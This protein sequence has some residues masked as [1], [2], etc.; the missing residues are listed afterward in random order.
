MKCQ[1][2][3]SKLFC[4]FTC[5]IIL[6]LARDNLAKNAQKTP[7]PQR[8]RAQR[9]RLLSF[10]AP[11]PAISNSTKEKKLNAR[12]AEIL[13]L[14]GEFSTCVYVEED[15]PR[16]CRVH[17]PYFLC[18]ATSIAPARDAHTHAHTNFAA[19]E[20]HDL[21]NFPSSLPSSLHT[22]FGTATLGWRE[23]QHS[24]NVSRTAVC[25]RLRTV[26]SSFRIHSSSPLL[27]VTTTVALLC[28]DVLTLARGRVNE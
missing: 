12:I 1:H 5:I 25:F 19:Q 15:V 3:W 2:L 22:M 21:L 26:F 13:Q 24:G 9:A 8:S 14:W 23:L 20:P 28:T 7:F 6:N 16:C 10:T 18:H 11:F 4:K 17:H 27:A